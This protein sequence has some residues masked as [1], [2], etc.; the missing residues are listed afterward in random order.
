MA[1][2]IR[3]DIAQPT[4]DNIFLEPI[5]FTRILLTPSVQL[6][7]TS[8]WNFGLKNREFMTAGNSVSSFGFVINVG[9][10]SMRR[11]GKN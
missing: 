9:E 5:F 11:G 2:F 8:G 10:K 4:E 7:Y 3:N 6:Q 1:E